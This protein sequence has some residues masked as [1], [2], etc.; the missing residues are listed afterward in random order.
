MKLNQVSP[1]DVKTAR[2]IKDMKKYAT[3]LEYAEFYQIVGNGDMP[4][5]KAT[6][7]GGQFRALNDNW[8]TNQVSPEFGTVNLKIFGDIVEVDKA[9]ERRAGDIISERAR[10]L[11][12]FAEEFGKNF[13]N[14]FFNGKTANN[15]KSW[16]GLI[17]LIPAQQI[18]YGAENGLQ[19]LAGNSEEASL[20]KQ[21][22]L[23]K[24]RK[25]ITMVDGGA[26]VL[27][28]NEDVWTRLTTIAAEYISWQKNDFGNM[29]PYFGGVPIRAG[30][31]SSNGNFII[32]ANETIGTF[33]NASSVYAMRFGEKKD[34]TIATSNGLNIEDL[35]LVNNHYVDNVELDA[36]LCLLNNR[37]VAALKGIIIS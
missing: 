12:N 18:I 27:Y 20:S 8:N 35:D 2:F 37:A 9:H 29:I 11:V 26:Q 17:S 36:D 3:I 16:N 5:K 22:F 30:G 10:Q 24:L 13:Q 33:N 32:P 34:L 7:A 28:M 19:V 14:E 15:P 23:E 31:Y 21:I 25:L 6:A 4:R 1:K